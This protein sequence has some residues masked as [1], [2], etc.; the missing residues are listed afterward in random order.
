MS[1]FNMTLAEAATALGV[2]YHGA[3]CHL[4]GI[5]TDSRKIQPG[6]LFIALRGPN[7]DGHQFIEKAIVNGAV[8]VVAEHETQFAVPA[9]CVKDSRLALGQLASAWR[10]R[11]DIPL[12]AVTGSNGK[13]TVKELLTSIFS[14]QGQPL[15]TQGNFNNEIGMPLTL[16]R[17]TARHTAAIIEMGANHP[18]EIE[19]LSNLACPTVALVNN[20]GDAHLEG[21]GSIEGVAEAKGEIYSGLRNDGVAVI[22]IDD[23]YSYIWQE[24]CE[25]KEIISFGLE[26][27]VDV[28]AKYS[29]TPMGMKLNLTT[30]D[31]SGEVLLPLLGRHNVMNALAATAAATAA[32]VSLEV[33]LAGLQNAQAAPGRLELKSGLGGSR[34]IDD[35]YNANPASLNAGIAVLTAYPGRHYLALGDMGELGEAAPQLHYQAGVEAKRRGVERLYAVGELSQQA[36]AGF[37]AGAQWFERQEEMIAALRQELQAEVT[38]LVKG[39]RRMHME[40]VVEAVATGTED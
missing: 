35:T 32:G 4:T 24:L 15:S 12:I 27:D 1:G 29:A 31:E 33:I 2:D 13:T 3:D 18:G 9:L 22:N 7:F 19:Y 23:P 26:Q 30:N 17:L 10:Q 14:Q 28:T 37:A 20:A 5:S 8:A 38:L 16:L 21:F 36:C 6:E 40:R 34:I 25:G 39:S 11:F